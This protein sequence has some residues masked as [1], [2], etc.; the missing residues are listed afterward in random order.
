MSEFVMAARMAGFNP[1]M[2]AAIQTLHATAVWR[3]GWMAGSSPAMTSGGATL[4]PQHEGVI[5]GRPELIVI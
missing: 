1:A 5:S 2:E 3:R 4:A